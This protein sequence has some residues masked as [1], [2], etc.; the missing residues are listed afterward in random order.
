MPGVELDPGLLRRT[1]QIPGWSDRGAVLRRILPPLA[2]AVVDSRS[3]SFGYRDEI[4]V[5]LAHGRWQEWAEEQA[6]A[7]REFLHAFRAHSLV[8]SAPATHP[9]QTLVLCAE[10]SGELRPDYG[11]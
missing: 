10:A 4:G 3:E 9:H 2:C 11:Y 1:W 7:V 8:T 6:T 5:S